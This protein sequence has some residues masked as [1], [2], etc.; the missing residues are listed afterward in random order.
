[1][2][3]AA[4]EYVLKRGGYSTYRGKKYASFYV[5]TVRRSALMP[6]RS[7]GL[8]RRLPERD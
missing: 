8:A 4:F 2:L 1:M 5:R 7:T 3:K 6:G